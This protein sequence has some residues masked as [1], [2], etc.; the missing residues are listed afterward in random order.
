MKK[1]ILGMVFVFTA[2]TIMNAKEMNKEIG[3]ND[4]YDS[5]QQYVE[6]LDWDS[7]GG[8][9]RAFEIYE[10]LLQLCDL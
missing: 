2:G 6:S 8:Q 7:P 3:Y 10:L 9:D 5:A 1:L 4:C